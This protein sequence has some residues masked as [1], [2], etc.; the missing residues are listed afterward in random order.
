MAMCVLSLNLN[1][2][3]TISLLFIMRILKAKNT[4]LP[5]QYTV[6]FSLSHLSILVALQL[7]GFNCTVWR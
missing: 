6:P 1:E 5:P 3:V 4:D 2:L 7:D